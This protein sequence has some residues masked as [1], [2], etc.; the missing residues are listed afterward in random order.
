M[1]EYPFAQLATRH[2]FAVPHRTASI[3]VFLAPAPETRSSPALLHPS[4]ADVCTRL[5]SG[6]SISVIHAFPE[7]IEQIETTGSEGDVAEPLERPPRPA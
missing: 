1:A 4:S 3:S 2:K 5:W 7:S 6:P